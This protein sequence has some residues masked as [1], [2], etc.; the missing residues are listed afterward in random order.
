MIRLFFYNKKSKK[1]V[2][3]H[4]WSDWS[5][6]VDEN[7]P[8]PKFEL[9]LWIF[10]REKVVDFEAQNLW[11][12]WF[13]QGWGEERE[14]LRTIRFNDAPYMWWKWTPLNEWIHM[15]FPREARKGTSG[16]VFAISFFF[17]PTI[18]LRISLREVTYC[19]YPSK[20]H[21]LCTMA[22][23]RWGGGS[24]PLGLSVSIKIIVP[25]F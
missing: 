2:G 17:T 4:S 8:L 7:F 20:F 9:P 16:Q 6:E 11:Q 25:V 13:I 22:C 18:H 3:R 1:Q 21:L 19:R 12:L 10:S 15:G 14:I 5:A 23:G 24:I